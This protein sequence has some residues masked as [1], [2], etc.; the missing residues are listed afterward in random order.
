MVKFFRVF[1]SYTDHHF[2][3]LNL[4]LTM[5]MDPRWYPYAWL[6]SSFGSSMKARE[7]EDDD[8]LL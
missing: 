3:T 6:H 7:D 5:I 4:H 2:C 8:L 1:P